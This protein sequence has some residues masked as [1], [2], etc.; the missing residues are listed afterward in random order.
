MP[1]RSTVSAL[2]SCG[3]PATS[4]VAISHAV[5]AFLNFP[6]RIC[7]NPSTT[8]VTNSYALV[9]NACARES[10]SGGA[11]LIAAQLPVNAHARPGQM[12]NLASSLHFPA[13]DPALWSLVH[14]HPK[15]DAS[16]CRGT[17][18]RIVSWLV[19]NF[20]AGRDR[21]ALRH[22]DGGYSAD[23]RPAGPRRWR[24]PVLGL[25]DLRSAGCLADGRVRPARQ[26]GA[27]PGHRVEGRR[28]RQEEM[29]LQP[30][31]GRQI[32]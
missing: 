20:G 7:S 18:R 5:A 19:H 31:P 2:A 9:C 4:A 25:H 11:A 29:A 32:P 17:R 13:P 1:I 14:A 16:C 21:C 8:W 24:L 3:S 12:L 22:F 26:T 27:G 10:A 6:L 23:H 30:A 15:S 28:G